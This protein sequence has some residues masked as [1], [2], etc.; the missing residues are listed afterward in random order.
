MHDTTRTFLEKA[1]IHVPDE[2]SV[3]YWDVNPMLSGFYAGP[4]QHPAPIAGSAV[5]LLVQKIRDNEMEEG[6]PQRCVLV[7]PVW[8]EGPSLRKRRARGS[9]R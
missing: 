5:D 8:R 6:T 2:V 9:G 3:I 7:E 1:G 4:E